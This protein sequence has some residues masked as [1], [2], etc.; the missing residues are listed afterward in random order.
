MQ[1]PPWARILMPIP[2]CLSVCC[3][4]N[5]TMIL[6]SIW[7]ASTAVCKDGHSLCNSSYVIDFSFNS[8]KKFSVSLT[9][10]LNINW[11]D[12]VA[13]SCLWVVCCSFGVVWCG[14]KCAKNWLLWSEITPEEIR[15]YNKLI[16]I[17]VIR[18]SIF[19]R[20]RTKQFEAE[21]SHHNIFAGDFVNTVSPVTQHRLAMMTVNW[22]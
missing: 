5:R 2:Y 18:G 6:V 21:I 19:I 14:F 20:L 15:I 10:L 16:I 22:Y 13:G 1:T 8:P 17:F 11:P 9:S 3:L 7:V 12:C 4:S